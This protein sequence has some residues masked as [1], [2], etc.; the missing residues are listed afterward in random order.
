MFGSRRLAK[1]SII[2]TKVCGLRQDGRYY[3]GTIQS[4][5]TQPNNQEFYSVYFSDND[6]K[7]FRDCDLIGP[8]FHNISSALLKEG[9]RIYATYNGREVVGIVI[10]HDNF[11]DDVSIAV[12]SGSKEIRIERTLEELRLM[13]SR[14]SARL[15]ESQ[16]TD[17]SKLADIHTNDTKKRTVSHVI[18][19]PGPAPKHRYISNINKFVN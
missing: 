5:Q 13:E 17:Y 18:D 1:R 6:T 9:Q 16:D 12:M 14:K 19:V 4:I 11:T 8:G 2:G 3:Q 15:Q 7:L 10:N